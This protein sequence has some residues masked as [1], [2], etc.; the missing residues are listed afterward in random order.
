[1]GAL[2]WGTSI[3]RHRMVMNPTP[4]LRT[5]AVE[6][7]LWEVDQSAKASLNTVH[8]RDARKWHM[9]PHIC[10]ACV[11]GAGIVVRNPDARGVLIR[12]STVHVMVVAHDANGRVVRRAQYLIRASVDATEEEADASIPTAQRVP[13]RGSISALITVVSIPVRSRTVQALHCLHL[14]TAVS[15]TP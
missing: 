12:P 5:N 7:P 10:S 13:D 8:L 15:T 2:P 14:V 6:A 4:L 11:T 1:M 9:V 3:A